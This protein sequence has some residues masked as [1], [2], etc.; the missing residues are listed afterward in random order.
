MSGDRELK[1]P[2]SVVFQINGREYVVQATV[3]GLSTSTV[4]DIAKNLIN[5]DQGLLS[6]SPSLP[7]PPD[8]NA[9]YEA[10]VSSFITP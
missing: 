8:A 10:F 4:T 5:D 3:D 9:G 1:V 7:N 6:D 2:E